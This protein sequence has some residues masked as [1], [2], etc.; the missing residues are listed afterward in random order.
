[1]GYEMFTAAPWPGRHALL[2]AAAAVGCQS[3]CTILHAIQSAIQKNTA[4]LCPV[5]LP[6][7]LYRT[8]CAEGGGMTCKC[9]ISHYTN[10]SSWIGP[11]L[12]QLAISR[13]KTHG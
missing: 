4:L 9:Y 8:S 5:G 13:R 12:R 1:M 3:H 2:T 6:L 11:L 7:R 10:N